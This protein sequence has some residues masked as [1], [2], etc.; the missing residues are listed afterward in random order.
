MA[1]RVVFNASFI[2]AMSASSLKEVMWATRL[3][4]ADVRAA[5]GFSV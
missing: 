5:A 3:A 1:G 4:P 2:S